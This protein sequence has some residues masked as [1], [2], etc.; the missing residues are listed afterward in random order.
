[1][2][3]RKHNMKRP[4][5]LGLTAAAIV[6][7]LV[8]AWMV[9]SKQAPDLKLVDSGWIEDS[10]SGY[11]IYMTFVPEGLPEDGLKAYEASIL[12]ICNLMAPEVVAYVRQKSGKAE[13]NSIVVKIEYGGFISTRYK[14]TLPY[15]NGKC[16]T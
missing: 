15:Q 5:I 11:S 16:L 2:G 1:M 8:L 6:M 4:T 12:A 9:Q 13:P 7:A 3:G 10:E 14:A